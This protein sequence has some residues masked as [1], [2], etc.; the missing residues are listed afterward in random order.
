MTE[1]HPLQV[2]FMLRNVF[3]EVLNAERVSLVTRQSC[4]LEYVDRWDEDRQKE[5]KM[6][7]PAT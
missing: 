4:H 6:E 3:S 2:L 7:L 5:S 1:F